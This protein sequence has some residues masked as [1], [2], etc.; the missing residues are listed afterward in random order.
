MVE[1]YQILLS[2]DEMRIEESCDNSHNRKTKRDLTRFVIVLQIQHNTHLTHLVSIFN[3][4]TA[5]DL[6]G[7]TINHAIAIREWYS[8]IP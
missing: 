3:R 7:Y 4:K 8:P 5:L 1:T 2:Q 6:W